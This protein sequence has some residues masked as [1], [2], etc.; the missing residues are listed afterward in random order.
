MLE[1]IFDEIDRDA[2]LFLMNSIIFQ[3]EWAV[4]FPPQFTREQQFMLWDGSFKSV[5]MMVSQSGQYLYHQEDSFAVIGLPYGDGRVHM[6]AFLP[7]EESSLSEFYANLNE[8]NWA[9]WMSELRQEEVQVVLPRLQLAYEATLDGPLTALGM[10]DAFGPGADFTNMIAPGP[11]FI[12]EVK[13]HTYLEVNEEGTK[14]GAAASVRIDKSGCTRLVF[15]RPFFYTIA[16]SET[17]AIL[18]IGAVVEP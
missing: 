17:G 14:A 18:F 3:G 9:S 7:S 13:H 10:G 6:I 4:G 15:D 12:G 1:P 8:E 11:G 2:A 5:P 16:D